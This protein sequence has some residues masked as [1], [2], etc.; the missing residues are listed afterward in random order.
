MQNELWCK[1]RWDFRRLFMYLFVNPILSPWKPGAL[2]SF[3][4]ATHNIPT[5]QG[6]FYRSIPQALSDLWFPLFTKEA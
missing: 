6:S 4:Y 3:E 1:Q 2:Y 5:S